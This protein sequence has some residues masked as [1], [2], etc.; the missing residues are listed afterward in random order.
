M[1]QKQLE[2]LS[3]ELAGWSTQPLTHEF[4]QSW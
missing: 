1:G 4:S 2:C 3:Q